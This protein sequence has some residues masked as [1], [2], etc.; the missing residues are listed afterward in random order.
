MKIEQLRLKLIEGINYEGEIIYSNTYS[1]TDIKDINLLK[2]FI[3]QNNYLSGFIIEKSYF[4]ENTY[5]KKYGENEF[6][7]VI[8]VICAE[9][10][11]DNF[12]FCNEIFKKMTYQII[13][14]S[15]L[16]VRNNLNE[17]LINSKYGINDVIESTN[18]MIKYSSKAKKLKK[19]I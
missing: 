4:K 8:E 17:L 19:L 3:N 5:N 16:E 7:P 14:N 15:I 18:E 6:E 1:L 2:L 12:K 13:K 10:L 9:E 11:N